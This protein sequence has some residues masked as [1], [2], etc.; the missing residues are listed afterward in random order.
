[1]VWLFPSFRVYMQC[2]GFLVVLA[3]GIGQ[4]T[5]AQSSLIHSLLLTCLFDFPL[6]CELFKYIFCIFS[7]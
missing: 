4:N 5:S 1:M 3:G 2:P 6:D 7:S